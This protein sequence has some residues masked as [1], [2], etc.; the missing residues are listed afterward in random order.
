MMCMGEEQSELLGLATRFSQR[1]KISLVTLGKLAVNDGKF[2]IKLQKGNGCTLRSA[3]KVRD[4][5]R[6]N[7]GTK[8]RG[9]QGKRA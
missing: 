1:K 7:R 4:Y 8:Y 9:R 2:F 3:E 6:A 5:I